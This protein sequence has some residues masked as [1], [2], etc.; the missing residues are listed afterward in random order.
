MDGYKHF[1][2]TQLING[3][4]VV[5]DGY[6]SGFPEMAKEGAI[7]ILEDGPRSFY[8]QWGDIRN[9]NGQPIYKLVNGQMVERTAD[10]L[11]DLNDYKQQKITELTAARD[12]QM[13]AGFSSDATG[14]IINFGFDELDQ[15]Y[16]QEKAVLMG[17]DQTT[18]TIDWKTEQGFITLTREQFFQVVLDGGAHK[19]NLVRELMQLEG[20]VMNAVDQASVDAIV[21]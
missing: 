11:F 21:W 17:I 5:I 10:E 15:A 2:V 1:A 7:L 16:L 9:S 14:T 13:H 6:T 19:E 20:L 8:Q 3:L 18:A 12:A 4:D